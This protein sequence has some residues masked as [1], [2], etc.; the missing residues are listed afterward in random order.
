MTPADVEAMRAN[1][2]GNVS[3]IDDQVGQ[4]FSVIEQRGEWQNTVVCCARTT[5]R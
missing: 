2:A 3:L 4:L 1:Y 5:A